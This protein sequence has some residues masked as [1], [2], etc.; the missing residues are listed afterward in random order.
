MK[1]SRRRGRSRVGRLAA[2]GLAALC[3][4]A[5]A[6]PLQ[7]QQLE[8]YDSENLAFRGIGFDVGHIWPSNLDATTVYHL[9][10]DLGYLGPGVRIAPGITYWRT[11]IEDSEIAAF[12]E[13]LGPGVDL[14]EIDLSDLALQLDAHF[15]WTTPIDLLTYLGLGAGMHALNGQGERID[16]TFIEDLFDSFM[17]G[18]S[19]I[20]GLEYNVIGRLRV[21]GEGR[22]TIVSDIMYPGISVGLSLMLPNR[23]Q[24]DG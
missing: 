15:V 18:F 14:G 4:L 13:Q 24:G 22:Y 2:L 19:L 17:P 7:A 10:V 20:G 11:S 21:Y 6:A 5:G 16:D 1:T 9:R 12:E 3:A 23:L 8:D